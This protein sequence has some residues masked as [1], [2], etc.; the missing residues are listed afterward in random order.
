V[1]HILEETGEPMALEIWQRVDDEASAHA[2]PPD[3]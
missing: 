3:G 2:R 1:G